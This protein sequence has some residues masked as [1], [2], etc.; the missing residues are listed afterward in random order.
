[1]SVKKT[2]QKPKVTDEIQEVYYVG[3]SDPVEVRRTILETSKSI[4]QAMHRY[5]KYKE[6]RAQKI[7][8]VKH[9]SKQ[10]TELSSIITSLKSSLP[11]STIKVK[12]AREEIQRQKKEVVEKVTE[13]IS[14]TPNKQVIKQVPKKELSEL[15]KLELE[16][17]S[18]ESKLSSLT[19]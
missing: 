1:M 5:E 2:N 18:I 19:K 4:I 16:L 10:M 3:V 13:K 6:F 11:K 8:L 14:N 7:E 17:S 15:E 12:K 9:L